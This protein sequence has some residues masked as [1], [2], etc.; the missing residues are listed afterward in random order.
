MIKIIRDTFVLQTSGKLES[1]PDYVLQTKDFSLQM[2]I[3]N[4]LMNLNLRVLKE[5]EYIKSKRDGLTTRYYINI[6]E[7]EKRSKFL[8]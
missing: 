8:L 3:S 6:E 7:N 1:L 5:V 2:G 4:Q